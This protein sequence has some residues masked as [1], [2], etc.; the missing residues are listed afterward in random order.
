MDQIP[1]V[2]FMDEVGL[3][4]RLSSSDWRLQTSDGFIVNLNEALARL[5]DEG[6]VMIAH[7]P[8]LPPDATGTRWG[9]GCCQ[10]QPASCPAG[11]HEAPG[12]LYVFRAKGVWDEKRSSVG[13]QVLELHK[14]EGHRCRVVVWVPPA[15]ADTDDLQ[16]Q[17]EQLRAAMQAIR[18]FGGD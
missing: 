10:W 17:M 5:S 13:G 15:M 18:N 14:L 3:M 4:Y 9:S 6:L 8:D 1:G 11:H 12:Y 7:H 16:G 2:F